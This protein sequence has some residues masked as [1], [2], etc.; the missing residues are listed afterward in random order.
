MAPISRVAM[1]R[2][3][4]TLQRAAQGTRTRLKTLGIKIRGRLSGRTSEARMFQRARRQDL[5]GIRG[6]RNLAYYTHSGR[7]KFVEV[8]RT[9]LGTEVGKKQTEIP[10][11]EQVRVLELS[12]GNAILARGIKTLFKDTV[13]VTATGL[14]RPP[15]PRERVAR[16]TPKAPKQAI[17][18]FK[19][20]D[21]YRVGRIERL[22]SRFVKQGKT[23]HFV[24][25]HAGETQT[26][27]PK[28]LAGL[29]NQI[30]T[31]DGRAYIEVIRPE[32][33]SD[34]N[35]RQAFAS[36]GLHAELRNEWQEQPSSH[37]YVQSLCVTR[38]PAT[39]PVT[40]SRPQEA[41]HPTRSPSA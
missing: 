16:P 8:F 13:E 17:Y 5:V 12:A 10:E 6:R 25:C 29:L 7:R 19:E 39:H 15:L 35:I 28:Y 22:I 14:R 38:L 3:M 33:M 34:S 1:R 18:P 30:L 32:L 26:L 40:G 37:L 24:V 41:G 31:P 9:D 21:D 11:T 23:F 2:L 36:Q 20:L 4:E 27:H